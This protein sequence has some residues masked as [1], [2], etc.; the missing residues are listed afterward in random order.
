MKASF[1]QLKDAETQSVWDIAGRCTSGKLKGWTL[2]WVDS[3]QLKWFAWAA[4]YPQTTVYGTE[5]PAPRDANK[6]VQEVAGTAEFLRLLPKPFATLKAV[7]PKRHSVTL[8]LEGEKVA[9]VWPVEPD[10]EI[11]VNAWWGR[12]E[13]FQPNQRVWAWLKLDRKQS[14]MSVVMLADEASE[15]DMHASLRRKQKEKPKFTPEEIEARRSAQKSWLRQH[16][17]TDGL[18]GTLAIHH[19]FSGELELA[20]DHEAMRWARSLTIGDVVHLTADPPIKGVVKAVAAWRERTIVRLVVGELESSELK[21][22]Q[23]I[24]LKMTPPPKPVENSPYPPDLDRPRSKAERVDW[25]LASIYCTCGVSKDTCTGHFYTLASC[26]PN[27]CGMPHHMRTTVAGLIDRGLT[28]RQIFDE[29]LKEF[30]PLLL[31]AHLMP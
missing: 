23:R 15:F 17:V 22:G 24:G 20:L 30:G 3:V 13:Q 25:F 19:I 6:K 2:E 11:K 1:G 29:L 12:L 28:D 4:E 21:T 5:T 31:R 27:G 10:A 14:P 8:L 16:W 26:N 9:K 18:P 7:D